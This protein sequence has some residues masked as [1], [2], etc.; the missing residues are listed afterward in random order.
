[1]Q[2]LRNDRY[3]KAQ[4]YFLLIIF[5][6]LA[7]FSVII[8]GVVTGIKGYI[9]DTKSTYEAVTCCGSICSKCFFTLPT[10]TTMLPWVCIAILLMGICAAIYKALCLL[11]RN[12][13]FIYSLPSLSLENH[14]KL[15]NI[16]HRMRF[17]NQLVLL[18][19]SELRCAFTLGL[20]KPKIYLSL[21]ICSYLTGKELLAVI[22]H[23]A[24][25]KKN[26]DPLKIFVIQI[27]YALNFFLPINHYLLNQFSYASE[28]EAD[29]GAIN[30]S[31]EPIELA[32]A[33]VKICKSYQT[34]VPHPLASYFKGQN[35]MEDRISRLLEPQMAPPIFLRLTSILPVLYLF[36]L[37]QQFVCLYFI[38]SLSRRIPLTARQAHVI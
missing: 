19:N 28:K 26:K 15:K 34:E 22:L 33:L 24:Q 36:L 12:Y 20:W 1:M 30:V 16:V 9:S 11:Y 21:G 13:R 18:D 10:I 2:Y 25:H 14:P 35:I 23:E 8:T 32:S 7:F 5:I 31:R 3:G 17:H 27:F 37:L 29:D 4:V 38:N 6:N